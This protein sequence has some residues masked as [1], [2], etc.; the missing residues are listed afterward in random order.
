M[1]TPDDIFCGFGAREL[2]G[3]AAPPDWGP[4]GDHFRSE[5]MAA[6]I[7]MGDLARILGVRVTLVSDVERGRRPLRELLAAAGAAHPEIFVTPPR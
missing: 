5:R 6:G 1:S 7:T 2:P 4:H 3:P